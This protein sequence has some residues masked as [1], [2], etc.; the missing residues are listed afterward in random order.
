MKRLINAIKA[1]EDRN[2][3]SIYVS[4]YSDESIGVYEFWSEDNIY[5]AQNED[6][7]YEFLFNACYQLDEN[8]LCISPMKRIDQ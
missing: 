3:T 8:G 5:E 6:D 1:F 2:N 7:L 4:F